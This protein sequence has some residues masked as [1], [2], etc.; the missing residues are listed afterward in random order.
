MKDLHYSGVSDL[1]LDQILSLL[2]VNQIISLFTKRGKFCLFS[3]VCFYW[4]G[5]YIFFAFLALFVTLPK[6]FEMQIWYF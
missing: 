6:M 1:P 3:D 2:V 4:I 5:S